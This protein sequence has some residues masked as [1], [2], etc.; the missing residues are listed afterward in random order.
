VDKS[1]TVRWQ[2]AASIDLVGDAVGRAFP[3]RL[4]PDY[5]DQGRERHARQL[6]GADGVVEGESVVLGA[7]GARIRVRFTR[8]P[9]ANAEGVVGVFGF[10]RVVQG[11]HSHAPKERH[12]TPRQHQTLRLL[13][14]GRSTDEL[15]AE[16]G[17]T[18]ETA[19]NYVR[20][21]LRGLGA[22]SRLEAVVQ[23]R[24]LGLL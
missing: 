14:A 1:G 7:D 8:I 19:R 15:V 17:V 24:E 12:L 2:N 13:A 4:A 5:R 18:R 23:A 22:H 9:L 21:V 3:T 16:L 6:L 20:Q 11:N 10:A